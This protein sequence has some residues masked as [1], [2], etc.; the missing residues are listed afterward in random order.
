MKTSQKTQPPK[1]R[2]HRIGTIGGHGATLGIVAGCVLGVFLKIVE[3]TTG[4]KVYTLLLNVDFIPHIPQPLPE[5]IEFVLH[6]L[7]SIG[8]GVG[9]I[10][11]LQGIKFCRTHPKTVG[12]LLGVLAIPS[13]FPLT[14]LSTRTPHPDDLIALLWWCAGHVLYGVVLASYGNA[15]VRRVRPPTQ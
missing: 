1:L 3:Q 8:I 4:E 12:L 14:S 11:L 9:Y 10:G 2:L 5:P 6:V 7:V 13:F 15:W